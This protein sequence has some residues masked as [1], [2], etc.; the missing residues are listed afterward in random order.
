[1]YKQQLR[2]LKSLHLDMQTV[3]RIKH[4]IA[5]GHD[6]FEIA[7]LTGLDYSVVLQIKYDKNLKMYNVVI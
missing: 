6:S 1:M 5:A 4:L 7:E 3:M 2:Y